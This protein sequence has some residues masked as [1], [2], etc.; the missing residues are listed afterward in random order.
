MISEMACDSLVSR[1]PVVCSYVRE[2]ETTIKIKFALFR[3]GGVGRGAG[4]KIVQNAIFH[5]K[6]HDNKILKVKILLS[7]NFVVMAQAPIMIR[8]CKY[9][10]APPIVSYTSAIVCTFG[11]S[12]KGDGGGR[13]PKNAM[14][15]RPPPKHCNIFI[16]KASSS[17][18]GYPL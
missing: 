6:R 9:E 2:S 7:R 11:E 14:T 4:R 15:I 17:L 12:S 16:N 13:Q 5:G 3:G 8:A 10:Y 18:C 1:N